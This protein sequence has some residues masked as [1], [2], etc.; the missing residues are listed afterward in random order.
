MFVQTNFIIKISQVI[1]HTAIRSKV[2]LKKKVRGERKLKSSK[3]QIINKVKKRGQKLTSS[4]ANNNNNTDSPKKLMAKKKKRVSAP[5]V[6]EEQQQQQQQSTKPQT[7][8]EPVQIKSPTKKQKKSKPSSSSKHKEIDYSSR[9]EN[10]SNTFGKVQ[11]WLLESPIVSSATSGSSQ[12]E[13]TKV[14]NILSKSQS[15]PERLTQRSPK[16]IKSVGNLNEKVKLQVVYKPPFKLSLKLSKNNGSVKTQIITPGVVGR[17][18]R[19]KRSSGFDKKRVGVD[20]SQRRTALLI[21]TQ[22]EPEVEQIKSEPNYETLNPKKSDSP[23]Y[24]NLMAQSSSNTNTHQN[25]STTS[26][27][28]TAT[29]RINKS[30]SGS[31]IVHNPHNPKISSSSGNNH[32][33]RRGSSSNINQIGVM[34]QHIHGNVKRR[35]SVS[36]SNTNLS[37]NLSSSSNNLMRSSTT[38]LTKHNSSLDRSSR[39]VDAYDLSRSST[40]NLTKSNSNFK[41][42]ESEFKSYDGRGG[43]H[44][45]E[46]RRNSTNMKTT[47]STSKNSI[48]RVS[49]ASSGTTGH[50]KMKRGSISNIPRASLKTQNFSRLTSLQVGPPHLNKTGGFMVDSDRRPMTSGVDS[51][52]MSK[53]NPFEWPKS[54]SAEKRVVKDEPL[55]SDLEVF[56]SDVENL[57][58]DH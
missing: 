29:F 23:V 50:G 22:E 15:T 1:V 40:T 3:D 48:S 26:S 8:A 41:K 45:G 36:T 55:P 17:S 54:L 57:M 25:T 46:S 39:P 21:R 14:T 6:A 51:S 56:V 5:I 28:N 19:V 16:K 43:G 10:H 11:K 49:N 33:N 24:E 38:N 31:N 44:S 20:A 9:T 53:T 58:H 7:I 42:L 47:D 4:S 27:V 32:H 35:S 34:P 30:A 52:K 12:I 13:H 37:K 2:P 18:K